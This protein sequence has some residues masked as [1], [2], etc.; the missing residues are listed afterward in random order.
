M[1]NNQSGSMVWMRVLGLI[2]LVS[3]VNGFVTFLPA[4]PVHKDWLAVAAIIGGIW[5]LIGI[6]PDKFV[7]V[8]RL[9]MGATFVYAS[10]HKIIFPHEFAKIIYYYK[11]MPGDLINVFSLFLPWVELITGIFLITGF[12]EKSAAVII[13]GMLVVFLAALTT[14]YARGIDISCGCFSNTTRVKGE[15][16][17]DIFRDVVLIAMILLILFAKEKFLSFDSRSNKLAQ[18]PPE[19]T[20]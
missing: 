6:F 8:L 2:L 17:S 9:A 14:A 18:V 11:I 5:G 19:A 10:I 12:W 7:F 3:G 4:S 15:V 1:S 13:S 20:A 16:L